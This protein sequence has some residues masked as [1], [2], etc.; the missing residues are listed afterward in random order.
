MVGSV[1]EIDD[2]AE[3]ERAEALE[4]QPWRRGS[5]SLRADSGTRGNGTPH[6]Q[7]VSA[8]A[9]ETLMKTDDETRVEHP[10]HLPAGSV[11]GVRF[12]AAGRR[13]RGTGAGGALPVP[14][15]G[16]RCWNVALGYVQRVAPVTPSSAVPNE[17]AASA[18]TPR[19]IA[20]LSHDGRAVG[21]PSGRPRRPA[22]CEQDGHGR[23]RVPVPRQD[24]QI[25]VELRTASFTAVGV[26]P[27]RISN[28]TSA[29]SASTFLETWIMN[30]RS[31][32]SASRT[33][34]SAK[35]GSVRRFDDM[36]NDQ[37]RDR[38][39]AEARGQRR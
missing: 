6:P 34:L 26:S 27:T 32:A 14:R 29:G 8:G 4:L 22:S 33:G 38:T 28:R 1:E 17:V 10:Y 19:K 35:G 16:D 21:A 13:G 2:P 36:Q 15:A 7:C 30:S 39:I 9:K 23:P 3:R 18:C 11:P 20:T 24:N 37:L 31:K 5:R 12:Q 25:D